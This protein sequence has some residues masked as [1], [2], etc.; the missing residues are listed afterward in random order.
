ME[1]PRR[2]SL[3]LGEEVQL[4]EYEAERVDSD[5]NSLEELG[6]RM[7]SNI[8]GGFIMSSRS[9]RGSVQGVANHRRTGPPSFASRC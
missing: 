7:S 2:A 6:G 4:H 1:P 3:G 5:E 8:L 9:R